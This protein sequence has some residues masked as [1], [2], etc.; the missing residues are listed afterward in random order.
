MIKILCAAA[1][2]LLA[3]A[4]FAFG[5]DQMQKRQEEQAAHRARL[6]ALKK[7]LSAMESELAELRSRLDEKNE[8][9]RAMASKIERFRQIIATMEQAAA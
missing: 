3:T 5:F 2:A 1:A 8:Q 7:Q 4:G 6:E 9:V